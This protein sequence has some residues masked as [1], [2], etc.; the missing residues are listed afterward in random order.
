MKKL[1]FLLPA[2]DGRNWYSDLALPPPL[3]LGVEISLQTALRYMFVSHRLMRCFLLLAHL[4]A[5]YLIILRKINP[6]QVMWEDIY[7]CVVVIPRA[8]RVT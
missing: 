3:S 4:V 8:H 5:I 6:M 1:L 7:I 2:S